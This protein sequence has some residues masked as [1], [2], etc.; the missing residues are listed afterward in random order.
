[1][2]EAPRRTALTLSAL[3]VAALTAPTYGQV[4]ISAIPDTRFS[5]IADSV[6]T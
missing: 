3:L 4:R 6:S 1:M 5:V 2:T